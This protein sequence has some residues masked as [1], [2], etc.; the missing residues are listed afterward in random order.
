[1]A[2]RE[3]GHELRH[4]SA[5]L[6]AR[7]H[8]AGEQRAEDVR[9]VQ[10][11]NEGVSRQGDREVGAV[12]GLEDALLG[13]RL[14][15]AAQPRAARRGG[16]D[17]RRDEARRR[18]REDG[19]AGNLE[20]HRLGRAQLV[21]RELRHVDREGVFVDATH[22]ARAEAA[23]HDGAPAAWLLDERTQPAEQL[24]G[25]SK[26]RV[27]HARLPRV[28]EQAQLEDARV[29][30]GDVTVSRAGG[31]RAAEDDGAG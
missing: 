25:R 11:V 20:R 7:A 27:P 5:R 12:V 9:R 8:Y 1:M 26:G 4:P 29:H 3:P 30:V 6:G 17:E 2:L 19:G 22:R 10:V 21:R 13:A 23:R 15:R 31:E 14:Q 24:G 18:A 16:D 28:V